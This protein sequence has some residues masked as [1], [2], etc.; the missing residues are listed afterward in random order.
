M[1]V[2]G[3]YGILGS[4]GLAG[5][6]GFEVSRGISGLLLVFRDV[7]AVGVDFTVDDF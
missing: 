1:I 3:W 6:L 5:D 2:S 4:I 7:F